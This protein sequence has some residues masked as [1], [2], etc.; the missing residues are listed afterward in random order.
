MARAHTGQVF[1][2]TL[3]VPDSGGVDRP[4]DG[5]IVWSVSDETVYQARNVSADGKSGQ[6]KPIAPNQRDAAGN[7]IPVRCTFTGD[8]DL[9]QGVVPLPPAVTEDLFTDQDPATM[10]QVIV[11]NMPPAVDDV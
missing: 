3:T 5:P 10:G 7:E 8:A 9:G 1:N 2:L 4:T 6:L 11:V